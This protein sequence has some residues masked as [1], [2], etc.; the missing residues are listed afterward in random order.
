MFLFIGG[1]TA[2]AYSRCVLTR[3]LYI[4]KKVSAFRYLKVLLMAAKTEFAQEQKMRETENISSWIKILPRL[5]RKRTL[6]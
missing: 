2:F 3:V 5:M 4:G 6:E 1:Q